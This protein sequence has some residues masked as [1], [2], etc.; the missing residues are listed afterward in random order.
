ML[1]S[2]TAPDGTFQCF[3]VPHTLTLLCRS[4]LDGTQYSVFEA[5]DSS[6]KESSFYT[7]FRGDLISGNIHKASFPFRLRSKA[8]SSGSGKESKEDG[9]INGML[10]IL[11]A[12]FCWTQP[13][14]QHP[15]SPVCPVVSID[16][17]PKP[18]T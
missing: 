6:G 4:P 9:V 10:R 2:D 7:C 5:A 11:K 18:R 13:G 16:K 1:M 8:N 14:I 3:H 17:T 12:V 15:F